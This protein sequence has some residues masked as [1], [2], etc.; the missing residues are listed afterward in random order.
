M[1]ITIDTQGEGEVPAEA[2]TPSAMPGARALPGDT[3]LAAPAQPADVAAR[4][5]AL[6]AIDAGPAPAVPPQAGMP[7]D[8]GTG[9]T[10]SRAMGAGADMA[11]GA[12]PGAAPEVAVEVAAEDEG[13]EDE[14]EET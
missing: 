9:S 10:G 12:A 6:G 4:A 5:A 11:A 8:L 2:G 13:D 3:E 14:G 7:L 1:R